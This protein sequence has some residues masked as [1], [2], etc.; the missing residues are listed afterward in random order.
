[1]ITRD[2]ALKYIIE[3]NIPRY[4]SLRWYMEI[5]DIDFEKTIKTINKIPK[6]Y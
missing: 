3:E 1:M 5:I 2:Q 4:D 6:L